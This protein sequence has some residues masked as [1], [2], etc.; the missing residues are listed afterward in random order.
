MN[1]SI[2]LVAAAVGAIAFMGLVACSGS[3]NSSETGLY[4]NLPAEYGK[5]MTERDALKEKAKNIKTEAEKAELIAQ[6]QK[7]DEEWSAKL[8]ETAKGL[9]GKPLTITDSLFKV[10][11]PV[12]LQFEK[13]QGSDLEPQFKVDGT[14][15]AAQEL[16]RENTYLSKLIVYLAGYDKEGTELFTS[17][18][19]TVAGTLDGT[20][21]VIPA[22]APVEFTH[23]RFNDKYV[24]EYPK[25]TTLK[26]TVEL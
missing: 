9:D 7:M 1:K 6:G 12:S 20:T 4:G 23:L 2:K 19:G 21:L 3:S 16:T 15:E 24:E 17:E 5:M 26:L 25:A 22:G 14:A 18:I 8:E 13:L 10:T 11:A